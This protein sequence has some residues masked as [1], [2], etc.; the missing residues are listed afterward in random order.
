MLLRIGLCDDT[1]NDI[2][3]LSEHIERYIIK[4]DIDIEVD[5][6]STGTELVHTHAAM[7]YHIIM[8][9]IEMPGQNG[10]ELAKYL[11][12]E[13]NDET[14]IIFT[15]SYP[16]Y[17]QDS[18]EFQPF[19]FLTKPITY[20]AFEKMFDR[21]I[22]K[23][24][25]S[26]NTHIVIDQDGEEHIIPLKDLIYIS[27]VKDKK[28]ILEFYFVNGMISVRGALSEYEPTLL[29][30]GF[31]SPSRGLLIN[32]RHIRSFNGTRVLMKNNT[33]LPVSRRKSKELQKI[34]ANHIINI[35]N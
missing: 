33:E 2:D 25:I 22:H 11:R 12:Y 23:M 16:K 19:G 20:D 4:H 28:Q 10:L 31:I 17:M 24:S 5:R 26:H 21:L 18:F 9:D 30:N 29:E 8:L 35:L 14:Y 27:T 3:I 1:P 15:T 6:F 32:I 13:I 7:Q 34:Y